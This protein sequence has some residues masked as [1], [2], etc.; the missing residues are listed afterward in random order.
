MTTKL[1][2]VRV[3]LEE[4]AQQYSADLG[5]S[6]FEHD[7]T[8]DCQ[9]SRFR[10][11]GEAACATDDLVRRSALERQKR[12][13]LAEIQRALSKLDDGSYGICDSC[14]KKIANGRLEALPY[15]C[16]CLSCQANCK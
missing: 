11:K 15:A 3:K 8:E 13:Q 9:G 2:S 7:E 1:F 10:E 6:I 4:L 14:G 16:N 5:L 12:R